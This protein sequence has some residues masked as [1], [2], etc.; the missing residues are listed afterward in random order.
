[1][2]ALITLLLPLTFFAQTKQE[3]YREILKQGIDHPKIVLAQCFYETKHLKSNIFKNNNN[4]FG[5]KFPY[6]RETTATGKD[7]NNFSIYDSWQS[8]ITDYKIW[9]DK[10]FIGGSYYQFIIDCGYC[11]SEDYVTTIKQIRI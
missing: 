5:M 8:S 3:V 7:S 4:A 10:Y 11:P 1:M 9:Q 6:Q 2:K